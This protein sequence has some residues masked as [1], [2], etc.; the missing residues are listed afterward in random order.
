EKLREHPRMRE[1]VDKA[2]KQVNA[3]Q[4]SYATVKKF[5]ILADDFTVETGE[6]TPSLKIRRKAVEE[7]RGETLDAFYTG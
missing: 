3:D 7:R 6:L 1:E 2:I 4:A 5:A